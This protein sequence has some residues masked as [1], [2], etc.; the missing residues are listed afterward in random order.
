VS[1]VKETYTYSKSLVMRQKSWGPPFETLM[2][3]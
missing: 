2:K 3:S 1:P